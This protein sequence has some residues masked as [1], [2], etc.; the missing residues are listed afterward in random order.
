MNP[1]FRVVVVTAPVDYDRERWCQRA[2]DQLDAPVQDWNGEEVI[3]VPRA[4]NVF[5]RQ[6]L[7]IEHFSQWHAGNVP[8]RGDVYRELYNLIHYCNE[9]FQIIIRHAIDPLTVVLQH[10]PWEMMNMHWPLIQE[11][12]R[13]VL[14]P[15]QFATIVVLLEETEQLWRLLPIQRVCLNYDQEHLMRLCGPGRFGYARGLQSLLSAQ[16]PSGVCIEQ[17]DTD[18]DETFNRFLASLSV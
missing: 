7:P 3:Y 4:G 14:T 13:D 5:F 15:E 10:D 9:N 2:A 17:D 18:R 16:N 8:P 11:R 12:V 1:N 6:G